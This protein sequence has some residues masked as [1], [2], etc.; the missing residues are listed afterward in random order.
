[1]FVTL[2]LLLA[3]VGQAIAGAVGECRSECIERNTYAIVRVHLKDDLVM[4]GICRN[5][6]DVDKSLPDRSLSVVTPYVCNRN[7]GTWALDVKDE[8]GIVGF[9]RTCPSNYPVPHERLAACA[10]MDI[11]GSGEEENESVNK[12]TTNFL[13][14]P[15]AD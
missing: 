1:M 2:I 4:V 3:D 7:N 12:V 13:P 14:L 5:A 10:P 15:I 9:N 6:S 11:A 8:E